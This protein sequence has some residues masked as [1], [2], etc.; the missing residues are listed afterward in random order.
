MH[1]I[2]INLRLSQRSLH[3]HK[4]LKLVYSPSPSINA[5]ND[6]ANSLI[7]LVA[8]AQVAAVRRPELSELTALNPFGTRCSRSVLVAR[9]LLALILE[10]L[11]SLAAAVDI[12]RFKPFKEIRFGVLSINPISTYMECPLCRKGRRQLAKPQKSDPKSQ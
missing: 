7:I 12:D 8:K 5:R 6:F 11:S 3:L 2:L 10:L 9:A 4:S 1:K